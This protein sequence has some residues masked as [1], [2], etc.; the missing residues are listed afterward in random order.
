MTLE[1]I[2]YTFLMCMGI[3]AHA[4]EHKNSGLT[5]RANNAQPIFTSPEFL[6]RMQQDFAEG[7]KFFEQ[8]TIHLEQQRLARQRAAMQAAQPSFPVEAPMPPS[9]PSR[10]EGKRARFV[11]NTCQKTFPTSEKARIHKTSCVFQPK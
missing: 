4:M 2:I 10:N 8:L 9:P 3:T 1:K 7:V 5:Q 11:C 6:R